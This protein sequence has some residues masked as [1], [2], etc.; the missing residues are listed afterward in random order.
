M[1]MNVL[2]VNAT[3]NGGSG[4]RVRAR[5]GKRQMADGKPSVSAA[6]Q[7]ENEVEAVSSML[8]EMATSRGKWEQ[9]AGGSSATVMGD[10]LAGWG[11]PNYLLALHEVLAAAPGDSERRLL[12]FRQVMCDGVALQRGTYWAS[13]PK[14]QQDRL[15]FDQLKHR[16]VME[17]MKAKPKVQE[18]MNALRPLTDE[19]R[20]AIVDKADEIMGIK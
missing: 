20:R 17:L 15:E 6:A 4:K 3:G 9:A 16:D 14:L 8:V 1:N 19:E 5:D 18:R 11:A 2:N 13:L 10:L 12:L 7:A